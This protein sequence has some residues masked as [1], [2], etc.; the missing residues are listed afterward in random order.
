M[1]LEFL[2]E[3]QDIIKAKVLELTNVCPG[4]SVKDVIDYFERTWI[5][6]NYPHMSGIIL[7]LLVVKL[8]TKKLISMLMH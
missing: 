5:N 4:K 6:G 8:I 1:P 2:N 7:T 3:C